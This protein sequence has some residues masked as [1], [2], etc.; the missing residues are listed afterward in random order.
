M[1]LDSGLDALLIALREAK[2]PVDVGEMLRLQRLLSLDVQLDRRSLQRLIACVIVQ[3]VAQKETFDWIFNAWFEQVQADLELERREFLS[4]ADARAGLGKADADAANA[5]EGLPN[6]NV[7]PDQHMAGIGGTEAHGLVTAATALIAAVR[8]YLR[9]R[10]RLPVSRPSSTLVPAPAERAEQALEDRRR[11][12]FEFR[13]PAL[14]DESARDALVWGISRFISDQTSNVLDIDRSARAT[15]AAG[16]I[17]SL[18]FRFDGQHRSVWLWVDE[19]AEDPAI[20]RLAKEVEDALV[21]SGLPVERATYFAVP[22]ILFA[23]DGSAFA[24]NELEERRDTAAVALLTDGRYLSI[25]WSA[26]D[27]RRLIG[28]QLHALSHWPRLAFVDFGE[29]RHGLTAIAGAHDIPVVRPDDLARFLADGVAARSRGEPSM[30]RLQGDAL[31]W[32]AVCA[33]DPGPVDEPTSLA[34][35]DSLHLKVTP[36]TMC[37]IHRNSEGAQGAL[38]WGHDRRAWLLDWLRPPEGEA[39]TTKDK[40]VAEH[41]LLGRALPFWRDRY[42][43]EH[44]EP[45]ERA[46]IDLWDRPDAAVQVLHDLAVAKSA[47]TGLAEVIRRRVSDYVPLDRR[48]AGMR[49]GSGGSD[50]RRPAIVL[51]WRVADRLDNVQVMLEAIGLGSAAGVSERNT[52]RLS[53]TAKESYAQSYSIEQEHRLLPQLDL[54]EIEQPIGA[55]ASTPTAAPTQASPPAD[56]EVLVEIER[57]FLDSDLSAEESKRLAMW[58]AMGELCA[59]LERRHDVGLCFSHVVWEIEGPEAAAITRSWAAAEAALIGWHNPATLITQLT[60]LTTPTEEQTRAVATQVLLAREHPIANIHGVERWLDRHDNKLDVRTLWLTRAALADLAGNDRGLVVARDRVLAKLSH[61]LSLERDVPTFLRFCGGRRDAGMVGRLV[62]HLETLLTR[63][64]KTTRTRSASEAPLELTRA[65]VLFTFA[66]GFALFGQSSHAR[67]MAQR[68]ASLLN[69][70]E[71]IHGFLSRAYA[72]RVEQ[73]LEGLAFE[74]PLPTAIAAELTDLD[75][76]SRFKVDRLRRESRILEPRERLDPF[77]AFQQGGQD[78]RGNE[79]AAMRGMDNPTQLAAEV[80]RLLQSALLPATAAEDRG[81]LFDGLMDF[82]FVLPEAQAVAGLSTIANHLEGVTPPYRALLLAEALGLAGHF[83]HDALVSEF[84]AALEAQF[85]RFGPQHAD[86]T[87]DVLVGYLRTLRRAGLRDRVASL[88][89]AMVSRW[90][91]DGWSNS[92]NAKLGLAGGLAYLGRLD[93]ARPLLEAARK[94]VRDPATSMGV[95]LKIARSLARAWSHAPEEHAIAALADLADEL[96]KV[97]DSQS[98]NSHFCLSVVSFMEGL[99][100]GI[101]S[102]EPAL[103]ETTKKWLHEDEYLVRRRFDRNLERTKGRS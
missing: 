32:A 18:R 83:G 41:S 94:A 102:E 10:A 50:R 78:P 38:Y 91:G 1:S 77:L 79:F 93:R 40:P 73:A 70:K 95:R 31:A 71:P 15:A 36:W 74:T 57:R 100:L 61:G 19:A 44:R 20:F 22:D 34:L 54:Q 28:A 8:L 90:T 24:P 21:Q 6:A 35:R 9:G 51:P 64:E 47:S 89:E 48:P 39:G 46:L 5:G 98:T 84:A 49:S 66:Y 68:A 42:A 86:D 69:E 11:E 99:V 37:A 2:L 26:A 56:E 60:K 45:I 87:A 97:T 3:S 88:L 80:E 25:R 52:P 30:I 65:Y 75:Q 27:Q 59:R 29:E 101:T 92:H 72:A 85:L 12:V 14:L 4:A 58:L 67:A 17:P 13:G 103:D 23:S 43:R 33:L 81:R 7:L 53:I 82:F 62:Q 16:G 63:F 96:P 55:K 76:F